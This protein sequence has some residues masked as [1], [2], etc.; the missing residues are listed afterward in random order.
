MSIKVNAG[1]LC[2]TIT[3]QKPVHSVVDGMGARTVTWTAEFSGVRAE[4]R[5]LRGDQYLSGQQLASVVDCKI[6]IRY[7]AG[8]SPRWRVLW[9]TRIFLIVSVIQP[10]M[11]RVYIDLMVKEIFEGGS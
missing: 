11:R 7:H 2:H 9:G 5:P 8:I 6:R 4:I 3:I 10:E 1:D